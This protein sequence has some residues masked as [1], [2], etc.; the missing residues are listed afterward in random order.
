MDDNSFVLLG[1][2]ESSYLGTLQKV[3]YKSAKGFRK[4]NMTDPIWPTKYYYTLDYVKVDM[5]IH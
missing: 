3:Y 1:L 2:I 5:M 4:F